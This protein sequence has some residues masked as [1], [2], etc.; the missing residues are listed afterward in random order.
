MPQN[1]PDRCRIGEIA[2]IVAFVDIETDTQNA[3]VEVAA[4]QAVFDQYACYFPVSIV[5]IVRPFDAEHLGRR[6]K[7]AEWDACYSAIR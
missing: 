4:R 2:R 6:K 3:V 7:G 1:D 5:Y